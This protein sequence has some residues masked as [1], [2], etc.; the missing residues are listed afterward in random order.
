MEK[1]KFRKKIINYYENKGRDFPWR[2]TGNDLHAL[3]AEIMLQQ[4][5][6]YQVEPVYREFCRRFETPEEVL[7][8]GRDEIRE[9]FSTLGL[10]NRS[11]YIINVS[12]FLISDK[13]ITQENL[14]EVK[15]IGKY[16]AN[17]YLSIHKGK[18]YPIVD[19]NVMRVF[20]KYFSI[21]D[22]SPASTNDEAWDLAQ[23]LLP[24]KKYREYNLGLLD[25]GSELYG[26]NPKEK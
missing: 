4:T 10:Q 2:N 3:T 9:L 12:K 24:E 6:Y 16:T 8:E 23:E 25:Y 22:N 17:A 13:K 5:S 20:K 21:E 15:G 18:R 14:L 7:N 26:K 19:G 11:N 1:E